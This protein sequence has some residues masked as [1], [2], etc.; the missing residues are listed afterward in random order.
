MEEGKKYKIDNGTPHG[1]IISPVLANVYFHF[2][3][4]L[5]FEKKFRK[6]FKGQAYI[7]RYT[8]DFVLLIENLLFKVK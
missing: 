3:L 2:V 4:D 6:Q 8:D 5:W 1:G 7:V